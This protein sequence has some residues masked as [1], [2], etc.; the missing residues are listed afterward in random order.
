MLTNGQKAELNLRNRDF[1][2]AVDMYEANP[3]DKQIKQMAEQRAN[4]LFE[5]Y[6]Q[7][8]GDKY[9]LMIYVVEQ[10]SGADWFDYITTNGKDLIS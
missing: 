4:R 2:N 8:F 5:L 3:T 1:M 7:L 10:H 6:K 9:E